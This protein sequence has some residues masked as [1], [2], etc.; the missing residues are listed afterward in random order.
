LASSLTKSVRGVAW[1]RVVI[2]SAIELRIGKVWCIGDERNGEKI[3]P[4]LVISTHKRS[5][6]EPA[7]P[8]HA[9]ERRSQFTQLS[10]SI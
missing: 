8:L 9:S 2:E 5:S 7:A 1:Q 4:A 10:C 6:A 3:I